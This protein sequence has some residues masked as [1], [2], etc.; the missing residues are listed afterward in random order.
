MK[1]PDLSTEISG[2]VRNLAIFKNQQLK[3]HDDLKQQKL[4]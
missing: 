3:Q 1:N 2:K 4:S